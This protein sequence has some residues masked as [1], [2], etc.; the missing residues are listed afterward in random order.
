MRHDNDP[1]QASALASAGIASAL[2]IST[3]TAGHHV[4]HILTKLGARNRT[5]AAARAGRLGAPT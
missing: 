3:K 5:E 1:M 4:S 2:C